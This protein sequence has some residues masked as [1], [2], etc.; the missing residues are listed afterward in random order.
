LV[1]LFLS[2]L[3]GLAS[4]LVDDEESDFESEELDDDS[5]VEDDDSE[6]SALRRD[7]EALSVR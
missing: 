1:S 7:D 6:R 3:A 2:D 4:D 5:D